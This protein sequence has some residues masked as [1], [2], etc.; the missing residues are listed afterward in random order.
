MYTNQEIIHCLKGDFSSFTNEG[1]EIFGIFLYGSQNYGLAHENSDID[2]KIIYF[3][4]KSTPSLFIEPEGLYYCRESCN[5]R[6]FLMTMKEFFT[7]LKENSSVVFEILNTDYYIISPK[8]RQ[9]WH[10]ISK[11]K[12]QLCRQ[13]ELSHIKYILKKLKEVDLTMFWDAAG[14]QLCNKKLAMGYRFF[15]VVKKYYGTTRTY[16]ECLCFSNHPDFDKI[17]QMRTLEL[18]SLQE[19]W[20]LFLLLLKDFEDFIIECEKH[21]TSCNYQSYNE[22]YTIVE[23]NYGF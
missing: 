7:E 13:D 9:L 10:E 21:P 20:Q 2:V 15:D 17:Q 4:D 16:K 12:D 18:Y 23:E 22:I 19:A 11:R 14:L 8:Y 3:E 5:G 6:V 1:L